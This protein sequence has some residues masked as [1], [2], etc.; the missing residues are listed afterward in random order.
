[1]LKFYSINQIQRWTRREGVKKSD[2][3]V[4]IISGSSLRR[5]LG[6]IH[7]AAL[8][9]T[10][11]TLHKYLEKKVV[12]D[13][14]KPPYEIK[15]FIHTYISDGCL[16]V[17]VVFQ[18]V[19][20]EVAV[21]AAQYEQGEG[22]HQRRPDHNGG[23]KSGTRLR[24]FAQLVPT[25]RGRVPHQDDPNEGEDHPDDEPHEDE[26]AAVPDVGEGL[27]RH[28]PRVHQLGHVAQGVRDV[29]GKNVFAAGRK[30]PVVDNNSTLIVNLIAVGIYGDRWQAA[31]EV[32]L[33]GDEIGW[34][35]AL[36]D[37]LMHGVF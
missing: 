21:H 5:L 31:F 27:L 22:Q 35:N 9:Q 26:P 32:G 8:P 6:F 13:V 16:R 2:N 28:S 33:G 11:T 15:G 36:V 29:P 7:H 14:L 20:L 4:D 34:T 23:H 12:S 19:V 24:E 3:F 1:M 17:G 30:D 10:L 18:R 37:Q 25:E